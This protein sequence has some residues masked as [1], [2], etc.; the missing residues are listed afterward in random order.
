[1]KSV[2]AVARRPYRST[3]REQSARTTRLAILDAARVLFLANGYVATSLAD[4]AEAAGVAR[5]TVFATFGSKTALLQQVL[6]EALAGDDEPVPVARRPWFK[7]VWN[8]RNHD[9]VLD[10]YAQV[11]TVIASRA[12]G[13]FEVVRRAASSGGEVGEL[14]ETLQRNRRAGAQMVVEHM[15]TLGPLPLGTPPTRAVDV[16]WVLN[17]PAHYEALVGHCGWSKDAYRS[18]LSAQ[19]CHGL[20]DPSE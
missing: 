7:P 4:I 12:A 16:L 6:D 13:V 10:A 9:A 19:M 8:A 18:W 20:F 3:V 11:C 5:P 17:D 2:K 14:W 15:L 1:M